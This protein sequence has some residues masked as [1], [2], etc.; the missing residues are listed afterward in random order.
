MNRLKGTDK[1]QGFGISDDPDKKYTGYFKD[2]KPQGLGRQVKKNIAFYGLLHKSFFVKG[3]LIN[4][5]DGS[6][7]VGN[8]KNSKESG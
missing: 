1:K 3:F 7:Y 8:F 2:N 5:N 6:F 4:K